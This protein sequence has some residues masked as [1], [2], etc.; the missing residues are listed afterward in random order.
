V[1]GTQTRKN[2]QHKKTSPPGCSDERKTTRAET[3]KQTTREN[4]VLLAWEKRAGK[5][6]AKRNELSDVEGKKWTLST[7]S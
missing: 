5:H 1:R 6:K 2:K 4:G 7:L 3:M